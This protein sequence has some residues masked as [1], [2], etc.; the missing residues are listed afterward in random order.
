M[1]KK[2]V[3][4]VLIGGLALVVILVAAL[5]VVYMQ[6]NT[7]AKKAIEQVGTYVLLAPVTV[8]SVKLQPLQGEV[9]MIGL[10][11]GNPEGYKTA[12]A[13]SVRRIHVKANIG[14]LR[15]DV[16]HINLIEVE[17]PHITVEQG[18]TDN[19]LMQL[20]ENAQRLSSGKEKPA[21]EEEQKAGKKM[22]IDKILVTDG[23]AGLSAPMLQGQQLDIP[24]PRVE[25]NDFGKESEPITTA[26]AIDRFI[27][28]L[29]AAILGAGK[30]IIPPDLMGTLSG[31]LD[32]LKSGVSSATG[33]VTGTAGE[34]G[35]A[36][37][38]SVEKAG[39]A[40]KEGVDSVTEGV[41]GIFGKK[42]TEK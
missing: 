12:Q 22:V 6:R 40:V 19:N 3:K 30:G 32:A 2:I 27:K 35:T 21:T 24:L 17:E 15:S 9:E 1:K 31:G 16:F 39:D 18:F 38:D 8:E 20:G 42:E 13:M 29:Y 36:V 37:K 25:M 41:K 5:A 10:K 34:A 28:E 33:T 23:K 4:I 11:V 14:S 26:D 7:I